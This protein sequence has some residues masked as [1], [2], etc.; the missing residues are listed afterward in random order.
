MIHMRE[1][2]ISPLITEKSSNQMA[3][4]NSYTFK[5]SMNANKVEIKNIFGQGFER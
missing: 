4:N 5:V 2:I 1:I 3:L